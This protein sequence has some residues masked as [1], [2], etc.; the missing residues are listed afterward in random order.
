MGQCNPRK[1]RYVKIKSTSYQ[2]LTLGFEQ[3]SFNSCTCL[4]SPKYGAA[5]LCMNVK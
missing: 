1:N 3:I 4:K 2:N 5:I